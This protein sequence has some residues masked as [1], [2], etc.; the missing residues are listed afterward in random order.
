MKNLILSHSNLLIFKILNDF[1]IWVFFSV[2]CE[3]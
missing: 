1:K 3:A 2:L